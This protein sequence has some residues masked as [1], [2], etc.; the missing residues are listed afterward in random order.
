MPA[1]L[2]PESLTGDL[3]RI[4]NE[5]TSGLPCYVLGGVP[6]GYVDGDGRC[7][8]AACANR[9]E[10]EAVTDEDPVVPENERP[11][12]WF[13][14]DTSIEPESCDVCGRDIA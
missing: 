10:F 7:L 13:L 4:R 12:T 9:R 5:E 3:S 14:V 2:L 1:L 11:V 6:V 8:C